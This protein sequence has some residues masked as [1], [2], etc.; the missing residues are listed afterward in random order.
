MT[1][2]APIATADTMF[3]QRIT[4]GVSRA[5]R[6]ATRPVRSA[7]QA[8]EP[9]NTPATTATAPDA[10]PVPAPM[11]ANSAAK[12]RIVAGFVSVRAT[13][14]AQP[15]IG[16]RTRVPSESAATSPVAASAERRDLIART[17]RTT[18]PMIP[19][20]RS[21]PTRSSVTAVRPKAATAPYMA[22][23]VATPTP[24]RKP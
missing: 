20:A 18:P 6:P 8:T 15:A 5:R 1:P 10:P 16:P 13:M 3:S 23:A 22:S 2:N 4:L 7:H 9:R 11:L 21:M 17:T 19:R 24:D 14:D 12:A